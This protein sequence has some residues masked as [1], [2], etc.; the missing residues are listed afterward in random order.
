[1]GQSGYGV[2]AIHGSD[3]A[4]CVCV[5]ECMF[6]QEVLLEFVFCFWKFV[7]AHEVHLSYPTW[8]DH[9][10][11]KTYALRAMGIGVGSRVRH[12]NFH[13]VYIYLPHHVRTTN[14]GS[15]CNRMHN[16]RSSFPSQPNQVPP[17]PTPPNPTHLNDTL[18]FFTPL[19]PS[20]PYHDMYAGSCLDMNRSSVARQSCRYASKLY[21]RSV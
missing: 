1:M 3:L 8:P 20:L 7:F 19:H 10:L 9:A 17:S 5:G 21:M 16:P 14:T 18:P 4:K 12:T 2:Y 15:T 11:G 13:S 6:N